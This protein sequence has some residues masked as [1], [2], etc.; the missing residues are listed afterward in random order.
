[1]FLKNWLIFRVW[2]RYWPHP[3]YGQNRLAN[4]WALPQTWSNQTTA[5]V[6][7]IPWNFFILIK[8]IWVARCLIFHFL[9]NLFKLVK[10]HPTQGNSR[11]SKLDILQPQYSRQ[12][13]NIF[14]VYNSFIIFMAAGCQKENL[15]L[16]SGKERSS[17]VLKKGKVSPSRL[18]STLIASI[19][20][21]ARRNKNISDVFIFRIQ[22]A[23]SV[24]SALVSWSP[25]TDQHLLP[26]IIRSATRYLKQLFW[27]INKF[28][29][30]VNFKF[31]QKHKIKLFA[32]PLFSCIFGNNQI[33]ILRKTTTMIFLYH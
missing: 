28:A 3:Q 32:E 2:T 25:I 9:Q 27:W 14:V 13:S 4:R 22:N 11:D 8:L 12:D 5:A 23:G 15:V 7:K 1:M 24:L 31:G 30:R 16:F 18:H 26:S 21:S 33:Y 6:K 10:S 17:L 20:L 29:N 19:D